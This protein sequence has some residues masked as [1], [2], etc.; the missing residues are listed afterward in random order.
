MKK[1]TL[2]I[3]DDL[4]QELCLIAE[5]QERSLNGQILYLLRQRTEGLH[6]GKHATTSD[7]VAVHH[8]SREL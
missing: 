1:I 5:E 6:D 2:R 4:H 7:R 8:R 3:P